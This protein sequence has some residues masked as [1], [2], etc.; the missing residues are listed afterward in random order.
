MAAFKAIVHQTN[1]PLKICFLVDG[2]DEFDGL[3]EDIANVFKDMTEACDVKVC[4]S[5]RPLVAFSNS[6]KDCPSLRLQDLTR[7][8]ITKYVNGKFGA[9]QAFNSLLTREPI[10]TTE[11]LAEI[12]DK[13]DGVFLWV[14]I[15]V[16]SLLKGVQN[17]DEI[18]ILHQRL[19]CMP[20]ELEPLY[21]HLLGLIE[22]VYRTWASKAFQIVRAFR[23]S[24]LDGSAWPKIRK[25]DGNETSIKISNL[26]LAICAGLEVHV[27]TEGVISVLSQISPTISQALTEESLPLKCEDTKVHLTARCAGLLEIPEF[28]Q[29]GPEAT[30]QFLHRT[31]RDFLEND[32]NWA[33]ILQHTS[34]T[35]FQPDVALSK[36]SILW[37]AI[38]CAQSQT[39]GEEIRDL[40]YT[41]MVYAH[42]VS[43]QGVDCKIET[44]TMG[45]LAEIMA[46]WDCMRK[47]TRKGRETKGRLH[48]TCRLIESML[49][50]DWKFVG[51]ATLFGL[52][53]FVGEKL[54][55]AKPKSDGKS[56]TDV[57]SQL[58][59]LLFPRGK[60]SEGVQRV[61]VPEIRTEMVSLLLS[62]GA[63][64]DYVSGMPSNETS[65]WS[66]ARYSFGEHSPIVKLL[67]MAR[68]KRRGPDEPSVGVRSPPRKKQRLRKA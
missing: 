13:A 39:T 56:F 29:Q 66:N 52:T 40:V 31:A 5:S 62:H 19:R 6:F 38:R 61:V 58:L 64:A 10:S 14:H 49:P 28:E 35:D 51:F 26:H 55:E 3:H 23:D 9:S 16:Q 53:G 47:S 27:G 32:K 43:K 11:L 60:W 59:H 68:R 15:V 7:P 1:I 8:D 30:I 25:A 42:R 4:L 44:A 37:L 57:V 2:L 54:L 21:G 36:A 46:T 34:K 17:R 50:L 63:N 18:S 20:Q 33:E 41:V 12:I 48:W 22:P 67:A 65:A 24:R 45:S